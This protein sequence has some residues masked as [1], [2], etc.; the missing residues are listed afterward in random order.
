[1]LNTGTHWHT[2]IGS[3]LVLLDDC[4]LLDQQNLLT[5]PRVPPLAALVLLALLP[6]AAAVNFARVWLPHF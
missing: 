5:P 6:A 3:G 4:D 2:Y 1:M